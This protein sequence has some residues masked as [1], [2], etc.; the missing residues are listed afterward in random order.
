MTQ[1]KQV[2]LNP[3]FPWQKKNNNNNNNKK[4]NLTTSKLNFNLRKKLVNSYIWSIAL[5]GT[6]TWLLLRKVDQKNVESSEMWRCGRMEEIIWTD[7]MKRSITK[8]QRGEEYRTYS[9]VKEG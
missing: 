1:D 3:E 8:S 7:L 6:E 9:K 2:K 5:C 4:K